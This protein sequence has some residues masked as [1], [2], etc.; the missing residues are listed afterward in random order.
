M[1][2]LKFQAE[3]PAPSRRHR[4]ALLLLL[5]V[6]VPVLALV[7]ERWRG[8]WALKSW[9]RQMM[10]KGEI[11][12]AKQLWPPPS[13]KSQEFSNRLARVTEQLP[14]RLSNYAGQMSGIVLEKPGAGR[15]GS[16]A[17]E[18]QMFGNGTSTNSWQ[19]LDAILRDGQTPLQSLR[20]MMKDPP[21]A[22]SYD[23]V[24]R[25]EN[26][27]IPSF[28]S[29][30]VAAQ[31]LHSA[32]MDD[33]HHGNL[34]GAMESLEALSGVVKLYGEDPTLV[35]FMIRIA[36]LGLSIDAYWDALQAE[37]WTEPQLDVLQ[38]ASR[39]DKM[40]SQMPRTMVGERVWRIHQLYWFRSHS[41]RDWVSRYLPFYQSF[42][43]SV[44]RSET[45]G[46]V[47]LCRQWVFHPIWSFAWADQEELNYL[48]AMQADIE[49]LRWSAEQG[50]WLGLRQQMDASHRNY[51]SPAAGWRFYT[52]LP[53]VDHF[54]GIIGSSPVPAPIY[55]H[56][57]FS[58]T[59]LTT[60][61]YL[62]LNQMVTTVIALKRYELRHGRLPPTI[63]SLVPDFLNE[64]PR[65]F[66]D[67][68]PLRYQISRDASF[69]LYSVGKDGEDDGGN[70]TSEDLGK[71]QQNDNPWAGRDWVWPHATACAKAGA[72]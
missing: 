13:P 8:Q 35:C 39:C 69:T 12:D 63:A 38:Q 62:T 43:M 31:A 11:F 29:V 45:A 55:P 24:K 9:K 50:S 36:V 59:W 19:D 41:Y 10:A 28:V 37:G 1:I 54:S 34:T 49:T 65:D 21:P 61:K 52:A 42:G 23:L 56:A 68:Q 22:M 2:K 25:L 51:R 6:L 67:G 15:R 3:T 32:A 53:L 27:S 58:R 14:R 44:P 46:V 71:R 16:Q 57:N 20:E 17:M 40:L 5:L 48:H 30:R 18:P 72:S 70:P 4:P 7:G 26:D 64:A 60:M 33:L 47:G 66:M